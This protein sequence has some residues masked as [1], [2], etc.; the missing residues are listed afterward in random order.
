[1]TD[2]QQERREVMMEK[3]RKLL[4]QA[5]GTNFE[6]EAEAATAKAMQLMLQYSIEERE[7]ADL[8][9]G[10]REAMVCEKLLVTGPYAKFRLNTLFALA[11]SRGT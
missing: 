3:I 4:A 11:D 1:M 6:A 5:N 2:V 9:G 8:P 7:I 10:E